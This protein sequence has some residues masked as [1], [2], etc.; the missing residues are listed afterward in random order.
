MKK[1]L[2]TNLISIKFDI[3]KRYPLV[4]AGV[5]LENS[6]KGLWHKVHYQI[7]INLI[8]GSSRVEAVFKR[9]N[10]GVIHQAH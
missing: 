7:E 1:L 9:N 4:A 8:P 2:R 3:N 6:R 5:M 10:I